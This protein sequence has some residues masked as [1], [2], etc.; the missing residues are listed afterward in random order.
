MDNNLAILLLLSP[1]AGFLF[2]VFFGKKVSR[3]ISGAIGTITVLVSFVLSICFFAQLQSTGKAVEISL[4]DWISV[5]NF[6]LDFG[7]LLDQLSLLWLLFV[8]GIGSLIH[9]YS[10]SYM[11]DDE[12]MHKFFAY[13]NL[14][15]FFMITLVVGSNLLVMFIGWEGVGLCSY[16]LIGFW[17]KNQSYNDAA[18]KSLYH[19]PNWG[20]RLSYRDVYHWFCIFKLKLCRNQNCTNSRKY[21]YCIIRRSSFM[22]IHRSLWKI[23]PITAI[24]LATGRD[25]RADSC[26]CIDPRGNDGNSRYLYDYPNE[27]PMYSALI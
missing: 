8:T 20:F 11:H 21:G 9:L 18:K 14:F 27:L 22:F 26:F 2:N 15:V 17:Y 6:K 4:F 13:L 7:F 12:N 1:F 10:I 24:H 19:E 16:L 5:H 25:G 3:G 23:S